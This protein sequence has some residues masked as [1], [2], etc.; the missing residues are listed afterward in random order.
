MHFSETFTLPIFKKKKKTFTPD[1]KTSLHAL[2]HKKKYV[3]KKKKKS[4]ESYH[5]FQFFFVD[6]SLSWIVEFPTHFPNKSAQH[7][8]LL[9][10][11]LTFSSSSYRASQLSFWQF[12][13]HCWCIFFK[14][15]IRKKLPIH[16]TSFCYQCTVLIGIHF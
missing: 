15:S 14:S 4:I 5:N 16:K 1:F 13:S 10:L 11:F 2:V 7:S 9:D 8:F 12:R 3:N 6:Q